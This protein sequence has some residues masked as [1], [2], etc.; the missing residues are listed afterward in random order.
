M[1]L[2]TLPKNDGWKDVAYDLGTD[3]AESA[4]LSVILNEACHVFRHHAEGLWVS[5]YKDFY[6]K[7]LANEIERRPGLT[8]R[9]LSTEDRVIKMITYRALELLKLKEG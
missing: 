4:R 8:G 9:L 1:A 2:P 5:H 6:A 7:Q 3:A